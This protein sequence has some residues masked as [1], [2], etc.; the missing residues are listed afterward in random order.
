MARKTGP[1]AKSSELRTPARPRSRRLAP[2]G[3]LQIDRLDM[4]GLDEVI[5]V[6]IR[7]AQVSVFDDYRS[8]T[9]DLNVSAAQFALMRLAPI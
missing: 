4:G 6:M 1:E 9:R 3:R 7:R 2:I 8:L 5:G